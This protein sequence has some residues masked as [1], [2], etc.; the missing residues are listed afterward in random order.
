MQDPLFKLKT[1]QTTHWSLEENPQAVLAE[2]KDT[3]DKH[4]LVG[5][6]IKEDMLPK[7]TEFMHLHL[8]RF[9]PS[10]QIDGNSEAGD[11]FA[12]AVRRN[13][14]G[15]D[16][17]EAQ[18]DRE[19][20]YDSLHLIFLQSLVAAIDMAEYLNPIMVY[21]AKDNDTHKPCVFAVVGWPKDPKDIQPD[22]D[23]QEARMALRP[24]K[25]RLAEIE[26]IWR[27]YAEEI[28]RDLNELAYERHAFLINGWKALQSPDEAFQELQF[29]SG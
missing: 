2:Q 14:P 8:V 1:Y 16:G 21:I 6:S 20:L 17:G 11:F 12:E 4:F 19:D 24:L 27:E 9:E 10:L 3:F 18:Y 13:V 26:E 22:I 15:K 23:E 7:L 25:V 29:V 5:G 28:E